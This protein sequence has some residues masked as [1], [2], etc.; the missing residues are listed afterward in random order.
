MKEAEALKVMRKYYENPNPD[1]A[2][3]FRFTEALKLLI[4]K[5][6]ETVLKA[7]AGTGFFV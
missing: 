2:E 4:D 1:E 6:G 5:T 3:E 7:V